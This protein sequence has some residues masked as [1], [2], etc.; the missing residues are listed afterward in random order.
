M[1]IPRSTF[2]FSYFPKNKYT[3]RDRHFIHYL[4]FN[5]YLTPISNDKKTISHVKSV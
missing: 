3:L 2:N 4:L 5:P 1:Y